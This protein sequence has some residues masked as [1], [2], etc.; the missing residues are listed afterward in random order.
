MVLFDL[1]G[2]VFMI[3]CIFSTISR[4]DFRLRDRLVG[5]IFF[6]PVLVYC[7]ISFLGRVL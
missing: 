1:Y 4:T 5:S 7:S 6:I 2:I 3:I